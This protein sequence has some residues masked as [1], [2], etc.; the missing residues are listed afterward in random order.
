MSHL[1]PFTLRWV[2]GEMRDEA[3]KLR[4]I[5]LQSPL[6]MAKSRRNEVRGA[7]TALDTYAGIIEQRALDEEKAEG[8]AEPEQQ[9][10]EAPVV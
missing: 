7:V 4:V 10:P 5:I 2:A 1:D 9:P 6:S 3:K 8:S